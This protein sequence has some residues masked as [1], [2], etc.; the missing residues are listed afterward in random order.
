MEVPE[1]RASPSFWDQRMRRPKHRPAELPNH[2]A[3]SLH[4]V[5]HRKNGVVK[6]FHGPVKSFYHAVFKVCGATRGVFK[7]G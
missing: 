6:P 1:E 4:G 2:M 7:A 5:V 3:F